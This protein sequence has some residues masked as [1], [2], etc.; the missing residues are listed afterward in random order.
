M[1][2][3]PLS[4]KVMSPKLNLYPLDYRAAS[5]FSILLYPQPRMLALRFAFPQA[6]RSRERENYGLTTFRV[7]ARVG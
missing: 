1:E 6:R 7:S 3:S 4:R 2:V 5:A